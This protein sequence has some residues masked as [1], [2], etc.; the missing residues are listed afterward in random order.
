MSKAE[1]EL[2]FQRANLVAP[3][4]VHS[5]IRSFEPY[6]IFFSKGEGS[7]LWDV[8]GNEYLDC[9]V[10]YGACILGHGHPDVVEAVK[11]QLESGL[12][13]GVE[14][15]LS[16]KLAER[17]SQMIPCGECVKFSNTG[18]EAVMK[19]LM[20]ARGYTGRN[21]TVKID[22]G[23]N[24][25]YDCV[26][27]NSAPP[28]T[29]GHETEL[30]PV[31]STGGI[32]EDAWKNTLL[33]PFNNIEAAESVIKKNKKDVAALIV[34]PVQFNLGCV[35]PKHGYLESLR[36][37]TQE[38]DVL[39]IFDEVISGFRMAPGGA[40]E[41]Y[42]VTPDLATFGK[43]V[44]N[45]FPLS[46]VTGREDIMKITKPG[47]KVS[48]AGLY[49]GSQ[50]SLAASL[51]TASILSKGEV[52]K[53]L[54]KCTAHLVKGFNEI[55]ANV[56]RLQGLAGQF[57]VYFADHE[58]VDYRTARAVDIESFLTF[59]KVWMQ[60]RIYSLPLVRFHHGVSAAHSEE[61]IDI[62]LQVSSEALEEA[63]KKR[64]CSL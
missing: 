53:H 17:L 42:G 40:Q 22:G 14:T 43:A 4:G 60:N 48:Y 9:V 52:Q 58:V 23:Y 57:Q 51:A 31:P 16:V 47:G 36:E 38:N 55:S 19:S 34:E 2:L 49:N 41:Y 35:T 32:L 29:G 24:G 15:E 27:T 56:A 6:P 33:I 54:Q 39:L 46:L 25:W 37:I 11:G 62:I 28:K 45:G 7:R 1:S 50:A 61:D 59:Q 63:A 20:I 30:T 3:G 5:N 64:T 12:T 18:T 44:A 10:N 13:C 21:K 8:D 26:A